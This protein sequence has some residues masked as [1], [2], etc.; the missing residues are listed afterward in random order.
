MS[1]DVDVVVSLHDVSSLAWCR[2]WPVPRILVQSENTCA[3]ISTRHISIHLQRDFSLELRVRP[4]QADTSYFARF[5]TI[6]ARVLKIRDFG[7]CLWASC[8]TFR[9]DLTHKS[10]CKLINQDH[11]KASALKSFSE[12]HCASQGT[13]IVTFCQDLSIIYPKLPRD[14]T[15]IYHGIWRQSRLRK[16]GWHQHSTIQN[17]YVPCI[18]FSIAYIEDITSQ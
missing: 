3:Y 17:V 8:S 15:G 13:G 11:W 2:V 16:D 18:Q 5:G 6:S 12:C 10:S 4:A 9:I 14:F 7:T 1:L